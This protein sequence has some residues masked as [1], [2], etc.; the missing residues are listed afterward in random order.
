MV[1]QN[2][3]DFLDLFSSVF[4]LAGLTGFQNEL[5]PLE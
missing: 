4:M 2:L 3:L 5:Q 1:P